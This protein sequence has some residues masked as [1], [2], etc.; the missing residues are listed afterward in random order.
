MAVG[1]GDGLWVVEVVDMVGIW[2][3]ALGCGFWP[4]VLVVAVCL[5]IVGL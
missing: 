1:F 2:P 3:W 4:W 5:V